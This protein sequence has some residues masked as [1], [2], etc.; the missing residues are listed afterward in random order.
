MS[1][2]DELLESIT[3]ESYGDDNV[4]V[5][6]DRFVYVPES[7]KRIAVQYDHNIETV[8]FDCP[9]YVDSHDMLD[10]QIYVNYIR[11]D[12]VRGSHLCTNVIVDSTDGN[13][14]HFDWTVSGHVTCVDGHLSFMVCAKE[15]DVD[16]NE[17]VH[18]N[19]EINTDMYVSPGIKHIDMTL[20]KYP[21]VIAQLI[22]RVEALE[23]TI[24]TLTGEGQM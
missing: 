24:T 4:V 11:A 9:R 7:L 10:M 14:I 12:G 6:I 1:Q 23:S 8:T 15:V 22:T 19:S 2:A 5:G 17:I 20:A 13:T 16:G 18:W 21:D 3:S